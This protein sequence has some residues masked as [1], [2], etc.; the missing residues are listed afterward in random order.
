MNTRPA[1]SIAAVSKRW[2]VVSAVSGCGRLKLAPLSVERAKNARP[3]KRW[4]WKMAKVT[5]RLPLG[6]TA[7]CVRASGPQS[8]FIGS[9]V[10]GTGVEKVRP[11]SFDFTTTTRSA[12]VRASH[13]VPSGAKAGV[14]VKASPG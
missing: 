1:G 4:S 3:L 13:S 7:I 10:T 12:V 14:A 2:L 5:I 9:G 8:S 6:S 11:R